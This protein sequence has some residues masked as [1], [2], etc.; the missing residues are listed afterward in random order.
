M[1]SF[2]AVYQE[3]ILVCVST[4]LKVSRPSVAFRAPYTAWRG[5]EGGRERERVE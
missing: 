1:C 3:P 2:T 4:S 5:R